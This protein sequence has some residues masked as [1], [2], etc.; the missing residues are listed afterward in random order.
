MIQVLSGTFRHRRLSTPKGPQTRPTTSQVRAAVF[1][2]CQNEVVDA[3]FLDICAGSGSMGI[4][5]ISRGAEHATFIEHD[6]F[7]ITA[8]RDNIKLLG[9]E[10][11]TQIIPLDAL[12]ALKKLK[13]TYSICYFDPPYSRPNQKNHFVF[14]MLEALDKSEHLASDAILF[15]EESAYFDAE[16]L[17]LQT[18]TL[19]SKRRFGDSYLFCFHKLSSP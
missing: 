5:A 8:I 7:A 2:I 16:A 13:G 1:N 6:R 3:R 4:E 15:L 14:D 19:A 10:E 18:L 12:H 11:K 9:I 17:A